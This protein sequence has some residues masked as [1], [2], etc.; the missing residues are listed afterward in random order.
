MHEPI[1]LELNAS[2]LQETTLRRMSTLVNT[3]IEV[4]L[5]DRCAY[6]LSFSGVH[7]F[8]VKI[9]VWIVDT[10]HVTTDMHCRSGVDRPE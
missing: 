10:D 2:V 9:Q 8:A 1:L 4:L 6:R 3:P 7:G 5:S